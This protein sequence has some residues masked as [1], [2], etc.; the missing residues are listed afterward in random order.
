[1]SEIATA[2]VGLTLDQSKLNAGL[3]QVNSKLRAVGRN[4]PLKNLAQSANSFSRNL[5]RIT[6]PLSVLS[7]AAYAGPMR[8]FLKSGSDDA[9]RLAARVDMVKA[10]LIQLGGRLASQKIFGKDAYQWAEAL[11]RA[12]NSIDAGKIAR[13]A[14]IAI[15][16]KAIGGASKAFGGLAGV[17]AAS[18]S[19]SLGG[20]LVARALDSGSI[21]KG[22]STPVAIAMNPSQRAYAKVLQAGGSPEAASY[23]ARG[24]LTVFSPSAARG[25]KAQ[26][27]LLTNGAMMSSGLGRLAGQ[28]GRVEYLPGLSNA[29]TSVT[30][31]FKSIGPAIL[32]ATQM[33]GGLALVAGVATA[34]W[35][36]T[37]WAK[38][39]LMGNDE[40]GYNKI[41]GLLADD[42]KEKMR[43]AGKSTVKDLKDSDEIRKVYASQLGQQASYG[44]TPTA[45]EAISLLNRVNPMATSL[46]ERKRQLTFQTGNLGKTIKDME[47]NG[48]PSD[49]DNLAI[50][51]KRLVSL[52]A[53]IA[54]VDAALEPMIATQNDALAAALSAYERKL[55]FEKSIRDIHYKEATL[56]E[57]SADAQR[58]V[59][60]NYGDGLEEISKDMQKDIERMRPDGKTSW[61]NDL[62]AQ[63]SGSMDSRRSL[64]RRIEERREDAKSAMAGLTKS[65]YDK[66]TEIEKDKNKGLADLAKAEFDLA[67][68]IREQG[69][70]RDAFE[71]W[72]RQEGKL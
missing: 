19:A 63:F 20:S 1:M 14:E 13:L 18:G 56:A 58:Q 70:K 33:L 31:A 41:M 4:D 2:S 38:G 17:A 40:A 23:A 8:A 11:A 64:N 36:A 48:L 59:L 37:R 50:S 7:A 66:Q 45:H 39:K 49:A 28:A 34:A 62:Q 25:I 46:T 21:S 52:E 71:A 44:G 29:G 69:K 47:E 35:L 6:T 30:A 68:E 43:S 42:N 32:S 61:T 57:E 12:I 5:A 9:L 26:Q 27:N 3:E 60:K 15:A 22:I 24:G 72:L 54:E 51:R 53:D 67:Q 10:S 55:A 16:M 65:S